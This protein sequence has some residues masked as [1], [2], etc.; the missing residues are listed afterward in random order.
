MASNYT[1]SFDDGFAAMGDIARQERSLTLT[2]QFRGLELNQAVSLLDV[3][4]DCA[5]L[6]ATDPKLVPIL[7]GVVCLHSQAFS[8]PIAAR[9]K[10]MNYADGIFQLSDFTYQDWKERQY[11]RV[12]PK[13]PTYITLHWRQKEARLCLEDISAHGM[14]VFAGREIEREIKIQPGLT[15]HLDFQLSDIP[16]NNLEGSILYQYRVG[17]WVEKLGLRLFPS[18][19]QRH[20][21]EQYI[22]R[23]RQEILEEVSQIYV[24][25]REP[26]G[27][28]SLYF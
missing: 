21:L 22:A 4:P 10:D 16:I 13:D 15:V 20:S 23:R 11:E 28:E 9:V 18:G 19:K 2:K 17:Q 5:T 7:E 26:R 12:Q 25:A 27:V 24:R 3:S 14:G 8:K 1:T 6:Q